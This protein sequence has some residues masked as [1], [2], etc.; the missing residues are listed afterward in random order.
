MSRDFQEHILCRLENVAEAEKADSSL[1]TPLLSGFSQVPSCGLIVTKIQLIH[2]CELVWT[3]W[4]LKPEFRIKAQVMPRYRSTSGAVPGK[5]PEQSTS[6]S[7][8]YFVQSLRGP[9]LG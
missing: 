1:H 6:V 7:C 3:L 5:A 9:L 4:N 2:D 8:V